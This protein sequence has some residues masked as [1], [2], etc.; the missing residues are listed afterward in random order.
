MALSQNQN[1]SHTYTG[2]HLPMQSD[3]PRPTCV[4]WCTASY[5]RVPDRDTIPVQQKEEINHW[6]RDSFSLLDFVLFFYSIHDH[7]RTTSIN[8]DEIRQ[9]P[10]GTF[11]HILFS[12]KL[13][14]KKTPK[15]KEGR[16]HQ[17][18]WPV[19][20]LGV[21]PVETTTKAVFMQRIAG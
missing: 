12:V 19:C 21:M 14:L 1:A 15:S 9:N 16:S 6:D 8:G 18:S 10:A 4:V 20:T 17:S 11:C 5:V 2:H 13:K 3:W 7:R